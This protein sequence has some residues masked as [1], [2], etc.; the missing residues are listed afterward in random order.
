[1][2]KGCKMKDKRTIIY[3]IIIS[4]F[5]LSMLT[6][7]AYADTADISTS[8]KA[9]VLYNPDTGLFISSKNEDLRL[10]MASTTKIMTALLA[11]ERLDPEKE[12]RVASEAVGVEGSSIYLSDGDVLK[13]KDLIYA[14]M[15]QSA[16][17]AATAL[18][19]EI[20]GDTQ[21]FAKLMNERA[22]SIGAYNTSFKNPHG[23]DDDEHF[24]T[25]RDLAL[26]AA[27]A[28]KNPKFQH[29]S[30]TYKYTF[31]IGD[32][33]RTVVN[34]NKLLNQYDGCIGVK[35]GYT[36]K[37]G[38]CL[39]SAANKDGITMIAVTLSAPDDWRDHKTML[40]YGYDV[41]ESVDAASICG[42]PPSLPHLNGDKQ[43]LKIGLSDQNAVF[44]KP[45]NASIKEI[46]L[47]LP[48]YTSGSISK[49]Q[50]I[51]TAVISTDDITKEYD[52]IALESIKYKPNKKHFWQLMEI[53]S[54]W[55]KSDYR[56]TLPISE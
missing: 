13:A 35:T 43:E 32:K 14:V 44:I 34:H 1:M 4:M 8:A 53:K 10:P 15:L 5:L 11:I 38:R 37:S 41:L 51:G 54:T 26:I 6:L 18:A 17:D 25:A 19:I 7:I 55:R 56:N 20:S 46:D 40:N 22:E 45:K 42:I 12:V 50:I 24:T 30:S 29:I 52:I 9:F 48:M 27:E 3:L 21:K 33:T 31:K 23:L 2:H 36:K 49:G 28:L 47:K 16:N 39:V